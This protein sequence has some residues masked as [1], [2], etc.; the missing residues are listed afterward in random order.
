ML[1]ACAWF[2]S[3]ISM[4]DQLKMFKEY[5]DKLKAVAGKK[6]AAEIISKTLFLIVT[7]SDDLANTYFTTPF[8]SLQY[9]LPS[10]IELVV[11]SASSFLQVRTYVPRDIALLEKSAL[12]W[13]SLY[14]GMRL[15][16][17]G[18]AW[19]GSK[20][21]RGGRSPPNR[22]RAVAED[23]RRRVRQAL[24]AF[25]QPG[26]RHAEQPP[27]PGVAEAERHLRRCQAGGVHRHVYASARP[28]PTPLRLW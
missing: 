3:A 23:H 13:V 27:R 7:G 21:D 15:F 6:K 5:K 25:I 28:D 11:Q 16:L 12:V 10:Y 20:K 4:S 24:R 2:Q 17:A 1:F 22:M 26:S 14:S 18:T 9:D 8:R 19:F